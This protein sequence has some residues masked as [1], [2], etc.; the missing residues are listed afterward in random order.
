MLLVVA[1]VR[2]CGLFL[3]ERDVKKMKDLRVRKS[4]NAKLEDYR[5]KDVTALR[6]LGLQLMEAVRARE[7]Y[8]HMMVLEQPCYLSNGTYLHVKK[9]CYVP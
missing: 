2:V 3:C 5:V 8:S 4:A 1:K 7:K 6:L 9:T